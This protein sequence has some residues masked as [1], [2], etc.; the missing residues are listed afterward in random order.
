HPPAVGF[1]PGEEAPKQPLPLLRYP[2]PFGGGGPLPPRLR[3]A[4]SVV[5][6]WPASPARREDMAAGEWRRGLSDRAGRVGRYQAG[7]A[8]D[9]RRCAGR[10]TPVLR[11]VLVP[12][13]RIEQVA[14][15]EEELE[16]PSQDDQRVVARPA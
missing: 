8:A 1:H 15:P 14:V 13:R 4:R 7:P 9:P 10:F 3:P 6:R 12:L 5:R 16:A 2:P 11:G